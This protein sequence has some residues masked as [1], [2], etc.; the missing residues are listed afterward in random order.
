MEGADSASFDLFFMTT[1]LVSARLWL[2]CRGMGRPSLTRQR[3]RSRKGHAQRCQGQAYTLHNFLMVMA[4]ISYMSFRV[5]VEDI[6]NV[7]EDWGRKHNFIHVRFMAGA[8]E[9]W[10]R[11]MERILYNLAPGGWVEFQEIEYT[12]YSD[13]HNLEDGH[14]LGQLFR[15]L[16]RAHEEIGLF[17]TDLSERGQRIPMA[18]LG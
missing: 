15:G 4:A 9:D 14:H 2:V 13:D 18:W 16:G 7:E 8:I 5:F 3:G 6:E 12:L 1:T 10:H 11:L 17:D